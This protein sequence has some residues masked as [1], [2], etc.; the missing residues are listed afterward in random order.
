MSFDLLGNKV[1][2]K[3]DELK[4]L[5]SG[6]I[7]PSENKPAF[8]EGIVAAVGDGKTRVKEGDRVLYSNYG[9]EIEV[10]GI[11]LMLVNEDSLIA[12]L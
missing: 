5:P 4:K 2:V 6:I 10:Q 8:R 9:D 3:P 1:L 11:K 12:I 7:L